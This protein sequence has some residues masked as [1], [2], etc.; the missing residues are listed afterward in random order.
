MLD[1]ECEGADEL[2][3]ELFKVLFETIWYDDKEELKYS[4]YSRC[5]SI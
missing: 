1:L 5:M 2:V 3:V 4:H